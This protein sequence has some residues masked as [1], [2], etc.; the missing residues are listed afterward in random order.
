[1][2]K[3]SL[4]LVKSEAKNAYIYIYIYIFGSGLINP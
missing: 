2:V 3:L 1:M 4:Y